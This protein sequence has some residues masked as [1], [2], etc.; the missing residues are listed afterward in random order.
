MNKSPDGPLADEARA[1]CKAAKALLHGGPPSF[2]VDPQSHGDEETIIEG[3]KNILRSCGQDGY[4]FAHERGKII[5]S[6][7][8]G[9]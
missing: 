5:I 7:S 1:L 8:N 9:S 2:P 4:S 3:A 6:W